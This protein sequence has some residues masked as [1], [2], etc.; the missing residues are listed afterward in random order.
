MVLRKDDKIIDDH[1]QISVTLSVSGDLFQW[2]VTKFDERVV[3]YFSD[4][5]PSVLPC[6]FSLIGASLI[7]QCSRSLL[8]LPEQTGWTDRRRAS[9]RSDRGH[10]TANPP[11]ESSY[12]TSAFGN[13]SRS[14]TS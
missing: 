5:P 4:G 6:R 2:L 12:L 9:R 3:Q 10:N 11:K 1:D 8:L 13:S 7:S 14:K